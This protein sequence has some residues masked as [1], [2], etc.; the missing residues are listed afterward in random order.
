[1]L[2]G[3]EEI[4][5]IFLTALHTAFIKG[6]VP[7]SL[8]LVAASGTAKSSLIK[9]LMSD[10]IHHTDSFSSQGLWELVQRDS[11]NEKKFILVPDMNPTLARRPT[12]V[13]STVA[14]LL[15]LLYDGSMRIDDGRAEKKCEHLPM[16]FI[17][18][19]TPE[20][21]RT[22][23]KRWFALGLRR[24]IIPMFYGYSPATILTLQRAVS[25]GT[26]RSGNPAFIQIVTPKKNSEPIVP[27]EISQTIALLSERF[28]MF[29]GKQ[30]T[31]R[32]T[33]QVDKPVAKWI[34]ENVVPIP[35][36]VTLRTMAQAHALK[37]KRAKCDESDIDFLTSFMSFCDP[38]QPRTL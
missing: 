31:N 26:I 9:R 23:A 30:Q 18:A 2:I 21:Y 29:L 15:T 10:F 19:M 22:Q 36:H 33:Y 5:D 12:T 4:E 35:P 37:D 13:S 7:V 38:E 14:N 32:L 25:K 27:E 28:A 24:R 16:G 17:S 6:S 8:I 34:S 11:K 20:I 3:L 1:M